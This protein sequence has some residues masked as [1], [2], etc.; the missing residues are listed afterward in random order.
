MSLPPPPPSNNEDG[1]DQQ[2]VEGESTALRR[3][4]THAHATVRDS[5]LQLFP[6]SSLW[7]QN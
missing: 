6:H 3:A 1:F 2:P 5:A 7:P 4:Y